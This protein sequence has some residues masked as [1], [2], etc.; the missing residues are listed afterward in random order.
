MHHP[1]K[2]RPLT[3]CPRF[4]LSLGRTKYILH[5]VHRRWIWGTLLRSRRWWKVIDHN[6]C[7]TSYPLCS[8]IWSHDNNRFGVIKLPRSI[9]IVWLCTVIMFLF[10]YPGKLYRRKTRYHVYTPSIV[11]SSQWASICSGTGK[12]FRSLSDRKFGCRWETMSEIPKTIKNFHENIF[13]HF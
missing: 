11:F 6:P 2:I 4:S 3:K 8:H 5:P 9:M 1:M 13:F 12:N 7:Q 10:I